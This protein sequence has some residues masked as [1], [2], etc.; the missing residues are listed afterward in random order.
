MAL[1]EYELLPGYTH[2]NRTGKGHRAYKVLQP[3][4]TLRLTP[5]QAKAFA[6]RFKLKESSKAETKVETQNENPL[7]IEDAGSGKYNVKKKSD[8]SYIN[9]AY[10][11]RTQALTMAGEQK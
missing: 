6:D 3:G 5:N 8:G 10:L 4:D 7:E 2:R 11:T 1:A 9:T